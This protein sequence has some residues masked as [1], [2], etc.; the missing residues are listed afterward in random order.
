M[1]KKYVCEGDTCPK[2]K[3]GR[4][5]ITFQTN[6]TTPNIIGLVCSNC[7]AIWDDRGIKVSN[8]YKY[9]HLVIIYKEEN[10]MKQSAYEVTFMSGTKVTVTAFN[11]NEA[12]ILAQAEQIKQG[13]NYHVGRIDKVSND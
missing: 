4:L 10:I 13:N 8:D 3:N 6:C 5:M 1:T 9:C 11:E 12:K 2:C 7:K